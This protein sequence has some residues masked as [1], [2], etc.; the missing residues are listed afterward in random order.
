MSGNMKRVA[1][2]G[3]SGAVGS[4]IIRCL[5]KRNFPLDSLRCFT[6]PRSVGQSV[7]YNGTQIPFEPL[8]QEALDACD[9][10]FMA[11]GSSVSKEWIPKIHQAFCI[12]SS[13]AFRKQV[14][15]I[16]PE[17]NADAMRGHRIVSS[18]NCVATVLLM[19]L[20]PLHKLFKA[21]RIIL[22]SYQAASG[23]GAYLVKH[24]KEETKA[25]LAGLSIPSPLAHPYAFNLYT[26]NSPLFD[27][28]YVDEEIKVGE[29]TRKIL[30][31]NSIAL[32]ATCV[33]VPVLRSHSISANIEFRNPFKLEEAIEAIRSMP[34]VIY[35]EDRLTNRFATPFD[36]NNKDEIFVG[37]LRI[38]KTQPNTL[39][40]WAVGDQLLKGAALNAVQIAESLEL[41][42]SLPANT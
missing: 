40:L 1:V 23:A 8:T 18:P 37:R 26:H 30:G 29:E 3:A 4:E 6:S 12:D 7:S 31:D 9:L 5:E 28:G 22:S 38:D 25:H 14:P 10:V 15:L 2:V 36:T 34:G 13:S 17:I 11:A 42:S 32:S 19:P 33:R 20:A 16:I 35:F 27:C 21:K 39:E 41:A 24:L